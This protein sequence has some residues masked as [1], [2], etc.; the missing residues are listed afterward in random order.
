MALQ[1]LST[2]EIVS[3]VQ[4][5]AAEIKQEPVIISPLQAMK[6]EEQPPRMAAL[7]SGDE[8]PTRLTSHGRNQA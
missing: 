8:R 6:V 5:Q 4:E 2:A 7:A 1:R 3:L